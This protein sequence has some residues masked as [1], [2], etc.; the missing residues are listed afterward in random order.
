MFITDVSN[1][2]QL[3]DALLRQITEKVEPFVLEDVNLTE[4]DIEKIPRESE[5]HNQLVNLVQL[6]TSLAIMPFMVLNWQEYTAKVH[7][8]TKEYEDIALK[9]NPNYKSPLHQESEFA[10]DLFASFA[11]D[12]INRIDIEKINSWVD[13]L[14]NIGELLITI[15][16]VNRLTIIKDISILDVDDIQKQTS[17]C[18]YCNC[19]ELF[20]D[21]I[22][23]LKNRVSD[24]AIFGQSPSISFA[25][26]EL[27]DNHINFLYLI[28]HP[29]DCQQM[30]DYLKYF[31]IYI[32]T[33]NSTTT[34]R[35]KKEFLFKYIL[36]ENTKKKIQSDP[37]EIYRTVKNT[38]LDRWTNKSQ[39]HL[40]SEGAY[41]D[42]NQ[43]DAFS[44]FK[45]IHSIIGH[46]AVLPSNILKDFKNV[47]AT[48]FL[49]L[50]LTIQMYLNITY[51]F[52]S[53]IDVENYNSDLSSIQNRLNEFKQI[54][55]SV[56]P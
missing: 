10:L 7:I 19:Y 54:Y 16:Q 52:L 26:R 4:T 33:Q 27:A 50:I 2:Q 40:L 22:T 43:T 42:Q 25:L 21:I 49:H 39:K 55:N 48:S 6:R 12:V 35:L 29:E 44:I 15:N 28:K 18:I 36:S 31:S 20:K 11:L 47:K 1:E 45:E 13:E 17:Y 5:K 14:L 41:N 53:M 51:E 9:V 32:V 23:L 3:P 8:L 38:R 30:L 56:D 46:S 24:N 34:L 37:K